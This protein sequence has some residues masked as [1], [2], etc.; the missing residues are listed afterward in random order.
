MPPLKKKCF[1][2]KNV[3]IIKFCERTTKKYIQGKYHK[4]RG[5][6]GLFSN[7]FRV[8]SI[9]FNTLT[10]DKKFEQ[11]TWVVNGSKSAVFPNFGSN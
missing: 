1:R 6:N 11:S 5:K 10:T 2:V 7:Y 3:K 8:S 9:Q 4:K